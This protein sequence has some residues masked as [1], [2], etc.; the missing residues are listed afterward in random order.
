MQG[1]EVLVEVENGLVEALFMHLARRMSDT[2]EDV[3][4]LKYP[5][6]YLSDVDI[7]GNR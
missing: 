5:F 6:A 7:L 2:E 1:R 3:T 4:G